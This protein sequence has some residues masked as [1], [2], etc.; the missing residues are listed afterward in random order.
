MLLKAGN[1][2]HQSCFRAIPLCNFGKSIIKD[3]Q[4]SPSDKAFIESFLWPI[5][6]WSIFSLQS[7]L[8]DVDNHADDALIINARNPVEERKIG[9]N[10]YH[11]LGAK[12]KQ[13]THNPLLAL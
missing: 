3:S 5:L 10:M 13:C 6:T 9:F 2:Y 4:C 1:I 8:D 11:L 7:V 12:I